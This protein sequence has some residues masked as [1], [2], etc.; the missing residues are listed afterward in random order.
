MFEAKNAAAVELAAMAGAFRAAIEDWA[1]T[2]RERRALLPAGGEDHA[3]PPGD[4]EARM[5]ILIEVS[6]RL[7]CDDADRLAEWLRDP[8][9]ALDWC[10]PL[11]AMSSSLPSLRRFRR[12]IEQ[13][14][15]A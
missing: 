12:F 14:F 4:T 2:W 15:D 8:A 10:S 11:E 7:T 6:R 3:T 5:R 9:E 13:G 1:L